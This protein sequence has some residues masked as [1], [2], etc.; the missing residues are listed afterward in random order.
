MARELGAQA[1]SRIEVLPNGVDLARFAPRQEEPP[2]D[3][4]VRA[5]WIGHLVPVKQPVA[6]LEA[7]AQARAREPGL[8]L[9]LVGEGPLEPAVRARI[10]ELG[11]ADTVS[12]HA[13]ADRE[14]VASHLARSHFLVLPSAAETFGVV[15]IEA[16]AAGR[17]V[18]STRSGGPEELIGDPRLGALVDGIDGLANGFVAMARRVRAGEFDPLWIRDHARRYGL[19]TLAGRLR[20]VYAEALTSPR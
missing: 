13:R 15:V 2:D 8:R 11:I 4:T 17:P 3:G 6:L 14:G 1:G 7:F 16:F 12:V 10:R 20:T 18:L 9:A 5:L 19:D